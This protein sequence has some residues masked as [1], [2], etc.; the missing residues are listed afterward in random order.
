MWEKIQKGIVEVEKAEKA[1]NKVNKPSNTKSSFAHVKKEEKVMKKAANTT[2]KMELP[3]NLTLKGKT[4]K[5][6][7]SIIAHL[8]RDAFLS[9]QETA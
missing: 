3:F 5:I 8:F 2:T 1:S 9:L 4:T 6:A 7:A